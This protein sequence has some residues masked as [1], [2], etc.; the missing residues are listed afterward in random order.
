MFYHRMMNPN[1]EPFKLLM[2]IGG[3][4]FKSESKQKQNV[5]NS[6]NRIRITSKDKNSRAV[7]R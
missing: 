7:L 4:T 3:R 5:D 2:R 1:T 6:R